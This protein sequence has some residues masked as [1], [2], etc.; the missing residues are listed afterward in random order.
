VTR[1]RSGA[2][3]A[4][5]G[6][7]L[8]LPPSAL[9]ASADMTLVLEGC[10]AFSEPELRELVLL[11][12]ATL[13]LPA[14]AFTLSVRCDADFASIRLEVTSDSRFPV[15]ARVDLRKTAEGAR[16][17]LVALA[18]TELLAQT[19]Q[20]IAETPATPT[21][22]A[23]GPQAPRDSS[24]TPSTPTAPT[25]ATPH[26]QIYAAGTL[27][28]MGDPA[29]KL[30]GGSLGAALGRHFAVLLDVGFAGGSVRTT[31]AE[32][33]WSSW[34]AYAGPL[35]RGRVGDLALGAGL[36]LRVGWL[37]LDA[38]AAAPNEGR[39]FSAPWA[40]AA[41]PL[42]VEAELSPAVVPFLALEGGYVLSPV[43]GN[44]DDGG[45]LAAQRGAWLTASAGLGVGF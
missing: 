15:E 43:R 41:L 5:G 22:D 2:A 26:S 8:L 34:T 11:E 44:V 6:W 42:R 35:L 37:A 36:G 32:V 19:E 10:S 14:R 45:A 17:R 4:L 31:L 1:I 39:D 23:A 25:Q 28:V 3:F 16:A 30:V 13:G 38:R 40:G 20:R 7:L 21:R 29:T 18:A 33:R 24:P 9:G 12:L 27:G